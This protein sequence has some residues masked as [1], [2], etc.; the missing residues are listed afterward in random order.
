MK[1]ILVCWLSVLLLSAGDTE[2]GINKTAVEA[3]DSFEIAFSQFRSS[4][5]EKD[6]IKDYESLR[7]SIEIFWKESP[8]L[9][10]NVQFVNSG[11]NSFG[12]YEPKEGNTF[13]SGDPIYLYME[14]I[15]NKLKRNPIGYYEFG[16]TADF[17]LEDEKGKILGGQKEFAS[18][19][20]KSWNFN[21]EISLTFTYTFTGF[22]KGKYK[23]V[24]TVKD[25][26][27]DKKTTV[28][29]WFYIR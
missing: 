29:N 23:I 17:T 16:F 10:N 26:F 3:T 12:I 2:K 13:T 21:T 28:E 24:T 19:N 14:P 25:A 18:L 1:E 5:E 11:D 27:S 8:L 20:F 6:Y 9:L 7:S 15:G 4:M 22:D